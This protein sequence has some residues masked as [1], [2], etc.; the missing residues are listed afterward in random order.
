MRSISDAEGLVPD[1]KKVNAAGKHLLEL[2]NSILDLSKIEAGKMELHLEDFSVAQMVEDIAAMIQP[3]AEKN[4]NRLEVACDATTGTMHAD[5][6]KVRQVLFNLL[7]NACKFTEKGTV[8]LAVQREEAGDD[9]WLS[10]SVRDTG[11]GST[12]SSSGG[13]FRSSRRPMPTPRA[14]TAERAWGL[15]SAGGC[16]G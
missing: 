2:I 6:T 14:S 10:F 16:A 9:A 3:L 4:G 13:C 5:L 8:S 15:R 11:I 12:P 1:L 7:S